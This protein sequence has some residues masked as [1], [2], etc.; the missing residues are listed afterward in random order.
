MTPP[1]VMSDAVKLS[2]LSYSLF[3][4]FLCSS[5]SPASLITTVVCRYYHGDQTGTGVQIDA[6]CS[7]L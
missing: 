1:L 2:S 5:F 3:F 4:L 6:E 7:A